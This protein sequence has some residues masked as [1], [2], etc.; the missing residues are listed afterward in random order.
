MLLKVLIAIVVYEVALKPA[1]PRSS[2]NLQSVP[3]G[4][5]AAGGTDTTGQVLNVLDDFL[6]AAQ[7]IA[8]SQGSGSS[9][10]KTATD[11]ASATQTL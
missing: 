11:N 5:K 10:A 3:G 6:K 4:Q 2:G 7:E 9:D 8:Q 1:P